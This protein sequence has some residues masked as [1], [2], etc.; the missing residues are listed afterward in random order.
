MVRGM[1]LVKVVVY[2]Y[3]ERN[4]LPVSGSSIRPI[5]QKEET[6]FE[7]RGCLWFVLQTQVSRM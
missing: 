1:V 2:V 5:V 3:A 7:Q 6:K 4:E